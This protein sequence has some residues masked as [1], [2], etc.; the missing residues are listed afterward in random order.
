MEAIFLKPDTK[1]IFSGLDTP[2]E[3]IFFSVW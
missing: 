3:V 1:G 2:T